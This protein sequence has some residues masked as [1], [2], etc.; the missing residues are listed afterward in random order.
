MEDNQ[1]FLQQALSK[2]WGLIAEPAF[3][4]DDLHS[5]LSVRI[6]EMLQEDLHGLVQ[7]M[8]RLDIDEH[9]FH[10]A[11]AKPG[12]ELQARTLT[13]L[14]IER[15]LQRIKFRQQYRNKPN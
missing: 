4:M 11:M 6:R 13:D 3:T 2:N 5:A 10:L 1:E 15:E 8:Y 7:T 12:L 14:I 9:K